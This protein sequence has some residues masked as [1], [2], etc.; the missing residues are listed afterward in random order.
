MICG[1]NFKDYYKI[2]IN[3]TKLNN[4]ELINQYYELMIHNFF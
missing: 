2:L 1:I 3:I 4:I